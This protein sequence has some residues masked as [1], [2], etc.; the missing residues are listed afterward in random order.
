MRDSYEDLGMFYDNIVGDR[1]EVT[2]YVQRLLKKHARN[3]ES[4]LEIACGTGSIL[5]ALDR[6]Y[7]VAGLDYSETMLRRAAEKVADVPLY[8]GDMRKFSIERSFDVALCMF[9][10]I[11]H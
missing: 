6:D 5:S 4:V 9:D 3:A 10:S 2:R 1:R 7:Q 11:N 8:H